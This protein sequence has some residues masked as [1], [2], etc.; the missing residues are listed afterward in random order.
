MTYIHLV[1]YA[2]HS[3]GNFD[4]LIQKARDLGYYVSIVGWGDKWEG[5]YKRTLDL[6]D[7]IKT[8]PPQEIIMCIDGFDS[9]LLEDMKTT[10]DIFS[11]Y[12]SP[13]VWGIEESNN[14]L[15]R[16]LFRSKYNYTLNG[17]SFMGVNEY[18]QIIFEE[19][20]SIYG[21]TNYKLDDQRIINQINNTSQLFQSIVKPDME[22]KI[23]ANL[24]YKG[25]MN[26]IMRNDK[27]LMYNYKDGD[28]HHKNTLIKPCVIS[29]PGNANIN[30]ILQELGYP[31]QPPRSNYYK[32][33]IT[34]FKYEFIILA[35][36]IL[37]IVMV[38]V[39]IV[40]KKD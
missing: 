40:K 6:Y 1:I 11:E 8:R 28:I 32:F 3:E 2:T 39:Q 17:G 20:I 5:F 24:I 26:T 16:V 13:V 35:L 34:N 4:I 9:I 21:K 25:Y 22:S 38:I 33:F 14:M 12:G 37:F 18:L 7:F 23:F 19:I 10:L 29:G 36:I 31:P 27:A 15:R 30:P